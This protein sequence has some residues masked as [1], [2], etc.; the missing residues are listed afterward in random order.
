MNNY[1]KS[2]IFTKFNFTCSFIACKEKAD[3]SILELKMTFKLKKYNEKFGSAVEKIVSKII[4]EIL[5]K[6]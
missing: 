1:N 3:K 5:I 4:I 6:K 2:C